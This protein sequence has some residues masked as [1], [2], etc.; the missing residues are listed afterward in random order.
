MSAPIT[1]ALLG[2]GTVGAQVARLIVEQ[3]DDLAAADVEGHVVDDRAGLV[4]FA[5][6]VDFKQAHRR[7]VLSGLYV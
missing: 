1:V 6:V 2:G 7:D 3:S 4:F 5:Q